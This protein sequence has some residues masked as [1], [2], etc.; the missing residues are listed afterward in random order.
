M[1]LHGM[2]GVF[3]LT[4]VAGVAVA[5]CTPRA[6]P[7]PLPSPTVS[8]SASESTAASPSATPPTMPAAAQGT[9]PKAAK[10]FAQHYFDL[11]NYSAR[12]GDTDALRRLGTKDC[13]SC[14]AIASNI[15]KIYNSG[16][17]IESERWELRRVFVLKS[18]VS[19]AVLSL[20]VFVHPEVIIRSDG[21]RERKPGGM[22]PMTLFL[23]STVTTTQ[24]ARLDLVS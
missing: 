4:L 3:L 2:T 17:Y 16:G 23:E 11:I 1:L 13:V 14:E 6:E 15:E 10:A 9:S 5:G 8:A 24:I 7:S 12:T 19:H 20:A 21:R 22:Q 18:T